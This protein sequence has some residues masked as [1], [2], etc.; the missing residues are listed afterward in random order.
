MP[1]AG[2]KAWNNEWKIDC[3]CRSYGNIYFTGC[4]RRQKKNSEEKRT[5]KENINHYDIGI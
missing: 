4:Y 3:D 5:G 1:F 2:G